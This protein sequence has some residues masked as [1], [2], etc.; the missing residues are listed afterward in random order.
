MCPTILLALALAA[1]F[2]R[3]QQP[4]RHVSQAQLEQ[5]RWNAAL[6]DSVARAA[7]PMRSTRSMLATCATLLVYP[8]TPGIAQSAA[9]S[10]AL[11]RD[12][13]LQVLSLRTAVAESD[14]GR[15]QQ[16][17]PQGSRWASQVH[18]LVEA[19]PGASG[20]S[21]W[22][23]RSSLAPDSLHVIVLG[24]ERVAVNAPFSI[25]G[26]QGHWRAVMSQTGSRW[27]LVCTEE[28]FGGTPATSPGCE[29]RAAR[30]TRSPESCCLTTR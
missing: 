11:M 15:I 5:F 27:K 21:F 3:T 7:R 17:L 20:Y 14:W 18:R 1:P 19:G 30:P 24:P 4:S 25:H 2:Q 8:C 9:D 13:R 28:Q 23:P 12:A 6:E 16:Y 29:P 26:A 10:V 22:H